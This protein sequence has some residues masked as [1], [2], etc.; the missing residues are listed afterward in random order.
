M[1]QLRNGER[2]LDERHE[3]REKQKTATNGKPQAK[4][5]EGRKDQASSEVSKEELWET[6]EDGG[7]KGNVG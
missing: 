7:I 3:H 4:A 1:T 2:L 6:P 5:T